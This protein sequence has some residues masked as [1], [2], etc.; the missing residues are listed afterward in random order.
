M[1]DV[2][3]LTPLVQ[4]ELSIV[5]LLPDS[6]T[7]INSDESVTLV[8]RENLLSYNFAEEN[9]SIPDTI[10]ETFVSLDSLQLSDR[11]I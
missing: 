1:W 3:I 11:T 5:D 10:V 2:A 8:F 7:Q 4:G 9:I 6:I